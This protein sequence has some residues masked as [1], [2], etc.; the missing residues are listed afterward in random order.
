MQWSN[1]QQGNRA[2]FSLLPAHLGAGGLSCHSPA[3]TAV[4]CLHSA[5]FARRRDRGQGVRH[6]PIRGQRRVIPVA[7]TDAPAPQNHSAPH[8]Y[9]VPP[10]TAMR[11]ESVPA[12]RRPAQNRS[13]RISEGIRGHMTAHGPAATA[14][15]ARAGVVWRRRRRRRRPTSKAAVRVRRRRSSGCTSSRRRGGT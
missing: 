5:V 6:L 8:A 15:A 13:R 2:G 10:C 11:G 14:H 7:R 9:S 3:T 1:P 4:Q 12:P